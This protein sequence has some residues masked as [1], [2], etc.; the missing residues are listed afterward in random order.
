MRAPVTHPVNRLSDPQLKDLLF[1]V[2]TDDF[3]VQLESVWHAERVRFR[4]TLGRIPVA[5]DCRSSLLDLGSTRAW[6]PFFQC[7]L[8][9][10]RIVLNTRYPHSG[11]VADSLRVQGSSPID[12]RVSVFDVERESF[13]LEDRSFDVVLCLEVLEHLAVDP[14][15][16][17]AEINRVLKPNGTLV[18]TTPNAIRAGN[19]VK[20]WLGEHPMGWAP[21][22]GFDSNR[23]NR[24]YTPAEV[25]A[26]LRNSGLDPVE[27]STFGAKNRGAVRTF[28]RWL[29]TPLL[30]PVPRCPL[31]WRRDVILAIGRRVCD[32][33]DRRPSW[34]YF[35][36]AEHA[37]GRV[38]SAP[39]MGERLN[40]TSGRNADAG[41]AS[42]RVHV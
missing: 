16:M 7:L 5:V 36:M 3:P 37:N 1:R 27:V 9:Y 19:L 21:Y 18:L 13:P 25:E 14:M 6:L 42:S 29:T 11:F 30:W 31:R 33:A 32:V 17:M 34:L 10:Q 24:E 15:A 26:L 4:E 20:A 23:H 39:T 40:R 28:L 8:G 2:S 41:P 12:L 22:N 35:D 38:G